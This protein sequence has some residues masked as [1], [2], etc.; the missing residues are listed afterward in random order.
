MT[1]PFFA[2]LRLA[3]WGLLLVLWGVAQGTPATPP[4]APADIRIGVLSYRG[5]EKA[6]QQWQGH[7]DYLSAKIPGHHFSIVPLS[8]PE[9]DQAVRD[10]TIELLITNTGHYTELEATG[11]VSRIATRLIAGP[12]GPL[13]RFGGTAI[14]RAGRSDISHYRD[15][16]G[17]TLLIP[18]RSSLG[19]WQVHV[20]EALDQGLD[21]ESEAHIL[22]ET[23]NHEKVVLGVLG[24]AADAGFIRSDLI[25]AM[26]AAGKIN[27]QD[28]KVI[29]PQQT[30]GYPFLHSTRLYPEWPLAR[31]GDFPEELSKQIL[32]ALLALPPEAPAARQAG[33]YGWTLPHNYQSVL[34]L[35]REAR[36]GPYAH[37]KISLRDILQR[38]SA[39]LFLAGSV[40]ILLLSLVLALILR[41]NRRLKESEAN[42]R[43]AAAVFRDAQEG[44]LITDTQCRIVDA[45][46]MV[47][48]LT[49]YTRAELI[50]QT[51]RLFR[52]ER[53]APDFYTKLWHELLAK[54]VWRGELWN[55]AK[56][57]RL[58]VQRTSISAIRDGAGR[59]THYVG[60]FSDM[61]ELRQNQ[62]QLA[63]LAHYDALTGLPNRVLLGDR[64]Q[65]AIAQSR[66]RFQKLA[67]CYLDL[68][69]FKPI[70]DRW[71][72]AAGDR[73]LVEAARRLSEC[74]RQCD[75]VSRL[76][77]DEFVILFSELDHIREC[78]QALQRIGDA[79][80][81]PFP[82][83]EGEA[84]VSASI[85]VSFYPGDG[86]DPDTLLRHADQAMYMAKQEGRNR[87]HLFR[88]H[89]DAEAGQLQDNLEAL[90]HALAHDEFT[91]HYQPLADLRQGRIVGVEAL[92]RWQ[93]PERGLLPAETLLA[94]V[95][96]TGMH[97]ALGNW[98]IAQALDQLERWL[99]N[100]LS[101]TV[102]VNLAVANVLH[103]D[104]PSELAA[105]LARHPRIAPRSLVLEIGET[106]A[107]QDLALISQSI[108]VCRQQGVQFA[109]DDFGTGYSSLAY[110]RDL[111]MQFLK[112]DHA[113]IHGMEDNPDD[114][115]VVDG[116]IGLATAFRRRTV[117]EGVE[118]LAQGQLLL[119][120]GCDLAQGYVIARPMPAGEIPAW[121]EAWRLPD[122]WR[123]I[124]RCPPEDLPLLSVEV[125]LTRWIKELS[126]HLHSA[127][128]RQLPPPPLASDAC[129]FG[130]WLGDEETRLRY[131]HLAAFAELD[132][133]HRA[134]H[135]DGHALLAQWA[136]D[137]TGARSGLVRVQAR[138][139]E[140]VGQLQALRRSLTPTSGQVAGTAPG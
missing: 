58:Y 110:L 9:L 85:G 84:T 80:A 124:P 70:N 115:A 105:H 55:R 30:P 16:A 104:F 7:A 69:N 66:R 94:V 77:G 37:Q 119:Q 36:L 137:P 97:P 102:C 71:G 15:L 101:L 64:L 92:I 11:Q 26:A 63:R 23:E 100:G 140:I 60:L 51:P 6:L 95:E 82:I 72:H 22:P 41:S 90:N 87:Y 112:V 98:V 4:A 75:T 103:P 136:D 116:A 56:G 122:V 48:Q 40:L 120:L 19:G 129:R 106:A 139:E 21:L 107:L 20:R 127:P 91:L 8:Y 118:T 73:L 25:E 123:N 57:G 31:V 33:L 76:G 34:D 44:I 49:G 126:A 99:D 96:Q 3:L 14:T 117:A 133:L 111:P 38:Y 113:F 125:D 109:I 67:V 74:V 108:E 35:F 53:Q 1:A 47:T 135:A 130:Q 59:L 12:D 13:N 2:A 18:D 10:H 54:D 138:R 131:G 65:Q 17:K 114:L 5:S 121:I 93:H 68:D 52:S 78:E 27:L 39:P 83:G 88:G 46:A 128:E 132:R 61:T 29:D 42:L 86:I 28:L 81:C 134:L 45:N 50:G 43:M 24:G 32:V 62:D 89:P 79:L